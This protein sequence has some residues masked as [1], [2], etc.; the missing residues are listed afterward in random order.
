MTFLGTNQHVSRGKRIMLCRI[1]KSRKC[2]N[3]Y[4]KY[5]RLPGVKKLIKIKVFY[6]FVVDVKTKKCLPT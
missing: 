6:L 3:N 4:G 1:E 2:V 5:C